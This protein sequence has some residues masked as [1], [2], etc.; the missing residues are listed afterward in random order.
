MWWKNLLCVVCV[1]LWFLQIRRPLQLVHRA[2]AQSSQGSSR[3]NIL[4]STPLTLSAV[5]P[6]GALHTGWKAVGS[7]L[8]SWFFSRRQTGKSYQSS[9]RRKKRISAGRSRSGNGRWQTWPGWWGSSRN[10][11]SWKRRGKQSWRPSS[12]ESAHLWTSP[13]E[14][15]CAEC[16]RSG[17]HWGAQV[18]WPHQ[19]AGN[20]PE[21]KP[22]CCSKAQGSLSVP[23]GYTGG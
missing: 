5:V 21:E 22:K 9:C 2:G 10:S 3:W 15:M 11:S 16:S 20:K 7:L 1:C 17:G 13:E 14:S 19:L 8:I 18:G 4:L 6:R 23:V 12:G